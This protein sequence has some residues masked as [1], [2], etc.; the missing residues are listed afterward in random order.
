MAE[1]YDYTPRVTLCGDGAYRW[2]YEADMTAK[3]AVFASMVKVCGVI[4]LLIVAGAALVVPEIAVYAALAGLGIVGLPAL[5]WMIIYR[6]KDA[7]ERMLYEMDEERLRVPGLYKS[8][9]TSF[10]EIRGVTARPAQNL[11]ELRTATMTLIQVFVPEED[12][13]FVKSFI[14]SRVSPMAKVATEA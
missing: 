4:A 1:T 9:Y 14:I 7:R 12:F 6:K 5:L 13:E 8:E 10:S 2:A 3:G 11:V